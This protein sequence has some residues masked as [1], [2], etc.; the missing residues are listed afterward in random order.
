LYYIIEFSNSSVMN[1]CVNLA[2]F[3]NAFIVLIRAEETYIPDA[4]LTVVNS[5]KTIYTQY[6]YT[7]IIY[8]YI[9]A[10]S[11]TYLIILFIY[12]KHFSYW[13]PKIIKRYGYPSETHVVDTD[14]SYLLEVHR[15]PHGKDTKRYRNFPVFLQHGLVASSADWIIGGPSKSLGKYSYGFD[16]FLTYT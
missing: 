2:V 13:Q 1:C 6:T 12:A 4:S 5:I 10:E 16:T 3:L 9:N 8:I 7:Y 11:E 15:I 14:D